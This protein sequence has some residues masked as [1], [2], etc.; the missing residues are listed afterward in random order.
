MNIFLKPILLQ[1][2]PLIYGLFLGML[3]Y[4]FLR[5]IFVT[6]LLD[7]LGTLIWYIQ[8]GNILNKDAV[9]D[10]NNHLL[11][12]FFG[13]YLYHVFGDHLI[14]Y[15]F[16]SLIS[17][18]IYFFS[19]KKLVEQNIK[20][21]Q[22]VIFLALIS[23]HWIF[24]YFG[25]SRGYAP[26]LAFW[27][28][29]LSMISYWNTSFKPRYLGIILLSFILCVL[30]NLSM[31]VPIMLLCTYLIFTFLL[32]WRTTFKQQRL[33]N[34]I[35]L[36]IFLS[37]IF[38]IYLQISKLK[39]ADAF[40]WGSQK[41]LWEVTGKS[42]SKNVVFIDSEMVKYGLLLMLLILMIV[43]VTQ[44]IK[45]TKNYVLSL[46][47]WT[48]SL[49]TLCLL[50][51]ELMVHVLDVNY[52][53]DRVAMYLVILLILSFG[54]LLS[55]TK[56]LKWLL[57]LLLWFPVS[58]IGKMN[59]NS[60]IFSPK[61]RITTS[62]Y[63]DMQ[64][65]IDKNDFISSDYVGHFCYAYASRSSEVKKMLTFNE[66]T[67]LMGEDYRLES[68]YGKIKN[69]AGYE[70]VLFDYISKMRLYKR[71]NPPKLIL[72]KDTLIDYFES[73]DL[74]VPL[75][76]YSSR[77][78]PEIKSIK[79]VVECDIEVNQGNLSINL[80]QVLS[81]SE[82]NT[83]DYG[84]T[85]LDWYFGHRMHYNFHSV[86]K[87]NDEFLA[88]KNLKLYFYNPELISMIIKHIRISIYA[89]EVL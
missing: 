13:H 27:M 1:N 69:L 36:S 24:D 77:D 76:N 67:S 49:L 57:L 62:F 68:H 28:L 46:P 30:S 55:E 50:S 38:L 89:S 9:L 6:P 40:W 61:D 14:V 42:V 8:S 3:L 10:A 58:F 54:G 33:T 56:G 21:F 75:L 60:T 34:L 4:L 7:E 87:I 80:I 26:S 18:P 66:S 37:I 23:V 88:D 20:S 79:I 51:A 16:L 81:D 31:I 53:Q 39:K 17:F 5:A 43:F 71:I 11:N 63:D 86:R 44:F 25:L 78:K 12:S 29:G 2:K 48:F 85:L 83:L 70:C 84:T 64:A 32:N 59:L 15:R 47:F 52:P 45:G 72:L 73:N 19:A 35:I 65:I 22:F 82:Q 41:G 74:Y